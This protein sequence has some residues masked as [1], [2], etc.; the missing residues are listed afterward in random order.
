MAQAFTYYTYHISNFNYMVND[1]QGVGTYFTDP[2]IN[3]LE[4]NLIYLYIRQ[5]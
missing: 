2:A 5:F 4:G 3:T 1:I